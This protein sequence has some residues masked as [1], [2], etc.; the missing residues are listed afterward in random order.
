MVVKCSTNHCRYNKCDQCI[1]DEIEV[2]VTECY[3]Y[4][5]I[6][7]EEL[8]P[9]KF[10]IRMHGKD[11]DSG[12]R[13]M[14]EE[15]IGKKININ[16]REMFQRYNKIHDGRTGQLFCYTCD[17]EERKKRISEIDFDGKEVL[18]GI[19]PTYQQ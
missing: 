17:L 14:W 6:P 3:S 2:D 13:L 4:L 18:Y 19:S 1:L 10:H 12:K 9:D 7:D 16:G 15:E 8:H 5:E 11:I